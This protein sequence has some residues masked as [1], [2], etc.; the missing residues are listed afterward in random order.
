M[1]DRA[2]PA[3]FLNGEKTIDGR[4]RFEVPGAAD[5]L[6]PV[7][8]LLDEALLA[9]DEPEP[10][11][12]SLSGW[13]IEVRTR[14]P[15]GMPALSAA[16][17][18]DE[19]EEESDRLSPP[20]LV[21]LAPLNQYSLA[22]TIERY[23]A[24]Y[25]RV[26]LKDG[27]AADDP[28]RLPDPFVKHYLAHGRS[29]LPRVGTLLTMP[30]VL[31]NGGLLATN[32]L[33]RARRAVFHIDPAIVALMPRGRVSEAEVGEA[34]SFL[35]DEWLVDVQT[36]YDGKCVLI[37]LA[38]TIIE[39]YLLGERPAFFAT[40]G[41]RG[42][43]K[44]TALNMVSLA[45]LGERAPAAA[46]SKSPEERRKTIFASLLQSVPFMVFDNVEAGSTLSC[47]VVE[48]MLTAGTMTDRV[49]SELRTETVSCAAIPAFTGN[50]IQPKGDLAS[51]SLEVRINV[52]RPDPENRAFAHPDPFGWTLD[53]RGKIIEAF[54]TILIG[55]PRLKEKPGGEKT[56]F[57]TWWRL[58][59]SA[60]EHAAD[61]A[62]RGVDFS[63]L[64]L[65]VEEKDEEALSLADALRRLDR[66]SAGKPFRAAEVLT[67]ANTDDDEGRALKAFLGGS[68][69]RLLTA[70]AITRKLNEKKDAP[71]RVD[72]AVWTLTSEK[73]SGGIAQFGIKKHE[74]EEEPE[75]L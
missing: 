74:K 14:A 25:K 10:P 2:T 16:G 20:E 73:T 40:A 53:H 41:K 61:L 30:L 15:A 17:A 18:N 75:L 19:E 28:K 71:T 72:D 6:L 70:T 60:I 62:E 1:M 33:D 5:E 37:A 22:L 3:D 58:V 31:K 39:R 55:N 56:R 42:G 66:L 8:R 12:R 64:F 38:L 46:W 9:V 52:D 27:R 47:P 59:G 11:M 65:E 21:A 54:Y 23:V 26:E 69:A 35:T 24:F 29:H 63:K 50:N 32:G 67:W 36:D 49:L 34:M 44:T 45:V 43:G 57:K 4:P 68:A 13:P 51:R 48:E 7:M